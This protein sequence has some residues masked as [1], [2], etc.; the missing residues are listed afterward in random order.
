M[1]ARLDGG[2]TLRAASV[3]ESYRP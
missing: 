1:P 2:S 3:I